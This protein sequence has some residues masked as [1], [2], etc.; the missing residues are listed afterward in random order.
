MRPGRPWCRWTCRSTGHLVD[1]ARASGLRP[2][3]EGGLLQQPAKRVLGSAPEGGITDHPGYEKHDPR[4][5][6]AA[7]I[8]A[9]AC[10]PEPR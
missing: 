8:P 4:P 1:R 7:G 5:V 10:G 9:T 2:T 3:G 6:R